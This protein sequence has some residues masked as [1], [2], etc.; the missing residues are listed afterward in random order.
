MKKFPNLFHGTNI[1]LIPN[2]VKTMFFK[3]ENYRQLFHLINSC[4]NLNKI[5]ANDIP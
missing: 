5:L 4:K 2:N 3:K 1:N